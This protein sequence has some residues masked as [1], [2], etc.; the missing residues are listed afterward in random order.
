M[1][2]VKISD[3]DK[4]FTTFVSQ[5]LLSYNKLSLSHEVISI[6]KIRESPNY[7]SNTNETLT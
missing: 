2:V 3:L 6:Y 4:Y 1:D 5:Y 7:A